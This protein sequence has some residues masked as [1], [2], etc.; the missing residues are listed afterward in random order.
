MHTTFYFIVVTLVVVELFYAAYL[1]IQIVCWLLPNKPGHS[2]N[3]CLPYVSILVPTRN[4]ERNIAT[5]LQSIFAQD[6]PP[7]R[8]EIIVCND[9]SEDNTEIEA[10]KAGSNSPMSFKYIRVTDIPSHKKKAIETGIKASSGELIAVTDADCVA[11][12]TW[13]SALVSI[14]RERNATMLCG[15]VA[16][17]SGKKFV[18]K[19]QELEMCGLSLLTGAGT[20]GGIP[21]LCNAAN[22]AYTRKAFDEVG[23]FKD[24]E[25]TP[26]G[27]D[28]LLM[29]KLHKKF[30]GTIHYVKSSNAMVYTPAQASLK[31]FFNQRIRWASKGLHSGYL[32]NSIVSLLIFLA[33]FLPLI[34]III[35]FIY[36]AFIKIVLTGLFLKLTIDFLLLSFATKFFKKSNLLLY[37]PIASVMVMLYVSLVAIMTNF[38]KY[39]WK[40][41]T[42]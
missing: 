25:N 19:F 35:L 9:H 34:C 40:G 28:T 22:L 11:E 13:I 18:E 5:C 33:N 41:R 7:H 31:D 30:P 2:K 20:R 4:E 39:T 36:P 42:Y 3:E 29:F 14:Y 17:T 38:Y 23:G 1:L 15:P 24:I 10:L 32:L 16:I 8:L 6:Y 37:Y 27:D 12:K 26:S 21:L